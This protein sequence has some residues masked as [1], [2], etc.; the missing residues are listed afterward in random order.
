MH[1]FVTDIGL[2]FITDVTIGSNKFHMTTQYQVEF[3]HSN[4]YLLAHI[5]YWI[6]GYIPL[7]NPNDQML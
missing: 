7:D 3:L 1:I 4:G 2:T 5:S 6:D